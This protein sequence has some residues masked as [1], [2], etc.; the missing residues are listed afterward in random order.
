MPWHE[1]HR[2]NERLKFVAAAQSGRHSMTELCASYG[3]S[4]K[5]GYKILS[6]YERD[7]PDALRDQSRAPRTHP[8]QTS[9]EDSDVDFLGC[10][11]VLELLEFFE[12]A[13]SQLG[14][15]ARVN[16]VAGDGQYDVTRIDEAAEYGGEQVRL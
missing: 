10:F 6:R 15:L 8:N 5:T 12:R 9:A 14:D 7:G 3:I 11:D 4:R 2:V 1:T 16:L 13:F